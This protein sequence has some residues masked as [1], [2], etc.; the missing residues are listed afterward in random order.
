MFS[1]SKCIYVKKHSENE[2]IVEWECHRYPPTVFIDNTDRVP[3]VFT[4]TKQPEKD[5][6]CGEFSK[7]NEVLNG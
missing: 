2:S 7:L 1:C 3:H 4:Y 5:D 6:W